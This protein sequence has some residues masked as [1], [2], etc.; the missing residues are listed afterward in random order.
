MIGFSDEELA[1]LFA[2][3][4]GLS[5]PDDAPEGKDFRA[6]LHVDVRICA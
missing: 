4:E 6:N 3:R 5:D 1:E 2:T